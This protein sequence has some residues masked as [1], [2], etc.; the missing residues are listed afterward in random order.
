MHLYQWCQWLEGTRIGADVRNSDWLFPVIESVHMLGIVLLVGA[1]GLFDLR[2][3]GR[4]PLRQQSVSKIARQ[5][6]PWVW[7]SFSVMFITGVLM[8]TSEATRCYQSW[9]FRGKMILLILAGL[10]A[11]IFQFGAYR[12]VANWD[13]AALQPPRPARF[14]A[15]TSLVLWVLI[16]FAGRGIAYY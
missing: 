4:G 5:V 6:M 16:V 3:L 9:C 8:F 10:N 14:A 11:F 15:G 12:Y 7:G 1:T 2:L 13:D